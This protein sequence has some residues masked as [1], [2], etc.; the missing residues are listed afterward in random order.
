MKVL[1]VRFAWRI[2][3]SLHNCLQR[4]TS[5]ASK[6][7]LHVRDQTME[8]NMCEDSC[9]TLNRKKRSARFEIPLTWTLHSACHS[10]DHRRLHT[11]ALYCWADDSVDIARCPMF[12]CHPVRISCRLN[13]AYPLRPSL[14]RCQCNLSSAHPSDD[15]SARFSRSGDDCACERLTLSINLIFCFSLI[16][17]VEYSSWKWWIYTFSRRFV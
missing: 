11:D 7:V 8:K 12:V 16:F 9:M 3:C 6:Q 2:L 17:S 1:F 13:F 14:V 5:S 4:E 10:P 15:C